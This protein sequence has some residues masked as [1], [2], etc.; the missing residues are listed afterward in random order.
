MPGFESSALWKP[1]INGAYNSIT[2]AYVGR[3]GGVISWS[4]GYKTVAMSG[5]EKHPAVKTVV[6]DSFI[7][8]G[9]DFYI[10]TANFNCSHN[11]T[12]WDEIASPHTSPDPRSKT[13]GTSNIMY[14][15]GHVGGY[16]RAPVI[17]KNIDFQPYAD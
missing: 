13:L 6:F 10:G 16:V 8:N 5:R 2:Y 9:G 17:L 14:A 3:F 1:D 4:S 15:D 12:N 7:N 11:G